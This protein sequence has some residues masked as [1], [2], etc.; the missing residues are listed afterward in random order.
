MFEVDHLI[1]L[2]GDLEA[3]ANDLLAGHG[4]ASVPG[5]RHSGHGTGNRIVPLGS[6]YLELMAVVDP[7]E[8]AQSPL[9]RWAAANTQPGLVPAALCLRTDDIELI[10]AALGEQP[11]AMSRTRP[12]GSVLAWDLAGLAGML[13]PHRLP[14]F[15]EWHSEPAEHPGAIQAEHKVDPVGITS[16]VHGD[17]GLTAGLLSA[18]PILAVEPHRKGVVSV[19]IETDSGSI[20][21][22]G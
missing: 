14:F 15:I 12:D 8:A 20:T 22:P 5:G 2:V 9:G 4:L 7:D 16:V 18:V 17:V 1:L 13:G 10:A 11:E 19:S 6:A 21:L 3:A